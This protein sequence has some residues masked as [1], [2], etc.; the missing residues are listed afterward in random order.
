MAGDKV[1]I[2]ANSWY[3]TNNV[4]PTQPVNAAS[5]IATI[6]KDV[7]S[8]SS[9]VKFTP[10]ALESSGLMTTIASAFINNRE[11]QTPPGTKPDAYLNWILFDNQ[12]KAVLTSD[13]KNSG[14]D[15]VGGDN[16][17]KSHVIT[18]REMSQSGYLYIYV[19]NETPNINVF[20]DNLHC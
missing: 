3:K 11:T 7:V 14:A 13:G 1:N 5:S 8:N 2:R 18:E 4:S 15:P 12:M 19:S 20:F 9:G 17:F 16:E 6:L 10:Q